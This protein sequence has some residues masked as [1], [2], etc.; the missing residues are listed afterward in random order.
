MNSHYQKAVELANLIW[1][2]TIELRRKPM[3]DAG[4]GSLL[5]IMRLANEAK[6]EENAT[7]EHIAAIAPEIYEIILFGSVA[8]GAENPGDIDLMILDNGHFSDF[9]PCNTDK[10]H[11]ENAYQDLGDNLVWLMYGWFNVNEVQL[12]KL[13]EGIEV[14]LHVLP[15][16]FLKL[17]TTRAAIADKHKDPNFFKNA[18]RAALRFNRITGE[19]EPF[20]LE[21]LEDRYRCNLS[22]IR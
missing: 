7:E 1:R 13:L 14:D 10:R 17:Q 16:R 2:K 8:A 9:F 22:D 11:T 12:Q 19:F 6:T 15:L 4:L 18:F 3:K 20:T 21:Y 5:S